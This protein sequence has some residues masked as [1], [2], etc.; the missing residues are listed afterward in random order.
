MHYGKLFTIST[1]GGSNA[2]KLF[3]APTIFRADAADI[4]IVSVRAP[5]CLANVPTTRGTSL[6]KNKKTK[7]VSREAELEKGI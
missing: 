6:S 4:A 2:Y 3:T 5:A 7:V 1:F